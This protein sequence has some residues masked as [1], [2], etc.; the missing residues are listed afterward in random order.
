MSDDKQKPVYLRVMATNKEA[1]LLRSYFDPRLPVKVGLVEPAP[2]CEGNGYKPEEPVELRVEF[3]GMA[4]P[5]KTIAYDPLRLWVKRGLLLLDKEEAK[6][7]LG[8][9]AEAEWSCNQVRM[10]H[11]AAAREYHYAGYDKS[12]EAREACAE[13][14][15]KRAEQ[16]DSLYHRLRERLEG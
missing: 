8:A 11:E 7:V 3:N 9:L 2:G 1:H 16:Y 14:N 12:A 4:P 6:I 10:R 15:L 5:T 13:D